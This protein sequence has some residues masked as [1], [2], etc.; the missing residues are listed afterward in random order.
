MPKNNHILT[1][2]NQEMK[3]LYMDLSRQGYSNKKII[4]TLSEKY[5][6]AERTIYGVISGEYER[7]KS[8]QNACQ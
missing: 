5:F 7:R 1:K 4:E 6:L 2:R 8:A 3:A